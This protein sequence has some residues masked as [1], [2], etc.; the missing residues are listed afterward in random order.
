MFT[1]PTMHIQAPDMPD[2]LDIS[3]SEFE[4]FFTVWKEKYNMGT[5]YNPSKD[6]FFGPHGNYILNSFSAASHVGNAKLMRLI[7]RN[8]KDAVKPIFITRI[9]ANVE[10]ETKQVEC[11]SV[12]KEYDSVFSMAEIT[13][14]IVQQDK[15]CLFEWL[16]TKVDMDLVRKAVEEWKPAFVKFLREKDM[17]T[18]SDLTQLLKR[19]NTGFVREL[20]QQNFPGVVKVARHCVSDQEI[21][22][23]FISEWSVVTLQNLCQAKNLDALKFYLACHPGKKVGLKQLCDS[24]QCPSLPV[25]KVLHEHFTFT[26]DQILEDNAALLQSVLLHK[27][28]DVAEWMVDTF[29]L[30]ATCGKMS[31]PTRVHLLEWAKQ[32]P[33]TGYCTNFLKLNLEAPLQVLELARTRY[34]S[35]CQLIW[36][37]LLQESFLLKDLEA[38]DYVLRQWKDPASARTCLHICAKKPFIEGMGHPFL[39][40]FLD[41]RM[42]MVVCL[43]FAG[44]DMLDWLHNQFTITTKDVEDNCIRFNMDGSLEWVVQH[45]LV[46]KQYVVTN[47]Y[48]DR[49]VD[50][51]LLV[52][53]GVTRDEVIAA[54]PILFSARKYE[55]I[56]QLH[57]HFK[58]SPKEFL[59]YIMA[60]AKFGEVDF[61]QW[62]VTTLDLQLYHVYDPEHPSCIRLMLMKMRC[63]SLYAKF[64]L[65]VNRIWDPS[66]VTNSIHNAIKGNHLT[67][68]KWIITK[69]NLDTTDVEFWSTFEADFA[70]VSATEHVYLYKF[71]SKLMARPS[72]PMTLDDFVTKFKGGLL[73]VKPGADLTTF[74]KKMVEQPNSITVEEFNEHFE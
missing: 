15:Q 26:T 2:S 30:H 5:N 22:T 58:F 14:Y 67:V 23:C 74:L 16:M 51:E 73:K 70:N 32:Q 10:D 49:V 19:G 66:S 40:Q 18:L 37:E 69:Y 34:Y 59:E 24:E 57:A 64:E 28:T 38:V 62:A 42:Y 20:L 35:P 9:L 33:A 21:V 41:R 31:L 50:V 1:Y 4:E 61:V 11:F 53:L 3:D 7:L 72:T 71:L 56:K 36:N 27:R 55:H 47:I 65:A 25:W 52:K 63:A 45:G 12:L 8:K 39:R 44:P 17:L 54:L 60:A 46:D 6:D 43:P 68:L 29:Q 13:E 48:P